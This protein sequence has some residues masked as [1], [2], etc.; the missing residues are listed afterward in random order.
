MSVQPK[1]RKLTQAEYL[2]IERDA[3]FR[4]EFYSGEMFLMAGG[5]PAHNIIKENLIGELYAQLKGGPCRSFS[6]DQRVKITP[7][8][9]YTYPDIVVVC[10]QPEYDP[11]DPNTLTNP[12]VL[13]EVLSPGA[14]EYDRG[15]KFR[16]YQKLESVREIV[17]VSQDCL[18]L[19]RFVRQPDD[20]WV[21]ATFD[22]PGASFSFAAIPATVAL[23]DVYRGANLPE[24]PPLR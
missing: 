13:I 20:T 17:F 14:A 2:S 12:Q 4:S 11:A 15:T 10:G 9:L 23:T 8:G 16:H 5:I 1:P 7:T 21:L 22:D 18:K 3:E 19:E 24:D 6:S